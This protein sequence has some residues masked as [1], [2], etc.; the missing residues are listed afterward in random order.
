MAQIDRGIEVAVNL[1]SALETDVG[2]ILQ[3]HALFDVPTS[4]ARFCGWKESIYEE[5]LAAHSL[6]FGFKEM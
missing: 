6:H 5:S 3:G 1:Q 4:R 2:A